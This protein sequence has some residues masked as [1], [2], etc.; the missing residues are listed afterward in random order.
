MHKMKSRILIQ[1]ED[2]R[3][4]PSERMSVFTA[5]EMSAAGRSSSRAEHRYTP[6][7][8]RSIRALTP[9]PLIIFRD[10]GLVYDSDHRSR[11]TYY[12]T[13]PVQV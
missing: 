13:D 11:C 12:R 10:E 1:E 2:K 3:T 8:A 5:G 6:S 7:P 9:K 4:Y